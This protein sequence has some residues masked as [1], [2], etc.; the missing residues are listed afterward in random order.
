MLNERVADRKVPVHGK[1][2]MCRHFL[3]QAGGRLRRTRT[4]QASLDNLNANADILFLSLLDLIY[5]K[6]PNQDSNEDSNQDSNEDSNQ[7]PIKRGKG[8]FG[9]WDCFKRKRKN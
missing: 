1:I 2:T 5:D 6:D 3:C 7:D 8:V 9:V 4:K